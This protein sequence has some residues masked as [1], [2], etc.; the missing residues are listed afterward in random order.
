VLIP[1]F[2][3]GNDDALLSKVARVGMS[4]DRREMWPP[5]SGD[6]L[7]AFSGRNQSISLD[8]AGRAAKHAAERQRAAERKARKEAEAAAVLAEQERLAAEARAEETRKIKA[9]IAAGKSTWKGA[10]AW[11]KAIAHLGVG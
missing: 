4:V 1:E 3:E 10:G 8:S 5:N 6:S 11:R 9:R 7:N 2:D